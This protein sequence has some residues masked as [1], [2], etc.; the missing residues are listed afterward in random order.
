[1]SARLLLFAA[2]LWVATSIGSAWAWLTT[3]SPAAARAMDRVAWRYVHEQRLK[4]FRAFN[5]FAVELN[6]ALA[7]VGRA[8]VRAA[9]DI[10]ESMEAF[11]AALSATASQER[12]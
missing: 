6:A 4:P 10:Q 9:R 2:R 3:T 7:G 1:V 12:P 8:A 11:Q 5:A